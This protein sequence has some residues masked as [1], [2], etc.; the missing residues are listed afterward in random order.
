MAINDEFL[1]C[2]VTATARPAFTWRVRSPT[3]TSTRPFSKTGESWRWC[4]CP[5]ELCL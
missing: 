5:Q 3:S 1:Y 4:L 2:A